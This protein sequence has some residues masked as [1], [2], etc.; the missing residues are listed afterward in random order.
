MTTTHDARAAPRDQV[1]AFP[2]EPAAVHRARAVPGLRPP[3]ALRLVLEVIDELGL[4]HRTSAVVG[5]GCYSRSSADRRR[6]LQC[7]HGRAPPWRRASSGCARGRRLHAPGRRRHG[8]RGPA[9]GPA[10]GGPGR[11]DHRHPV[12][13][14][15]VRRHRRPDDRDHVV[16]QRPR[17]ASRAATDDHGYPIAVARPP[18]P[19]RARPTWPAAPYNTPAMVPTKRMIRRAFE[20]QLAGVGFSSSRC[21]PCARPVGSS[22]PEGADYLDATM[23]QTFPLGELTVAP[24]PASGG[25]DAAAR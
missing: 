16:G 15:R 10:R 11:A 4:A 14:R 9:G 22:A 24:K 19:L 21:S 3:V 12:Q 20:L 5:H 1:A 6:L 18:A 2:A 25:H 23:A 7:L 13:Q 8:E 17:P